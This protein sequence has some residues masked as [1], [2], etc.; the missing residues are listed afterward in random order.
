M[1]RLRTPTLRPPPEPGA[2]QNLPYGPTLG[3]AGAQ[4]GFQMHSSRQV[5]NYLIEL[6]GERGR[7]LT[8]MQL[9]KLVY[10]CHGWMLGL[11]NRPLIREQVQAW[12]YG[13]V[14]PDLY[15]A[16][17]RFGADP[18]TRLLPGPQHPPFDALEQ[19][20]IAQVFSTYGDHSGVT[21]SEMTHL[22]GSPWHHIWNPKAWNPAI[23]DEMIRD[24]YAKLA[25]RTV[26]E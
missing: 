12:K 2:K 14:V 21:L 7:G 6:A 5:A 20:L 16:V 11:Y 10:M 4:L 17:R 25:G 1:V 9:I 8:P 18:V 23:P 13:P 15:R 19:D 22:P 26:A 24:Y 3:T